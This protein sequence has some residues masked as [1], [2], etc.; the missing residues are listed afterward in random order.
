VT[1][2]ERAIVIMA[3]MAIAMAAMTVVVAVD[4]TVILA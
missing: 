2:I 3:T 1:T 4:A